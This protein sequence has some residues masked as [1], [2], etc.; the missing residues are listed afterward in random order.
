MSNQPHICHISTPLSWRGGEQ[1]AAYLIEELEALNVPQSMFCAAGGEFGKRMK[2]AGRTVETASKGFSTNPVFAWKLAKYARKQGAQVIHCHDSHALTFGYLA[3]V[4]FGNRIPLVASR[5]VDFPIGKSPFSLNKYN[6]AIVGRIL[7]VSDAIRDIVRPAL[8]RP[9][10]A[11]TVYSGV[12]LSRFHPGQH[13]GTLRKEFGIG[14]DVPLI[15]TV[16]ALA[17]HKDFPTWLDTVQQLIAN[18][19]NAHFVIIGDGPMKAAVESGIASRNL[20][21]HVTMAGFRTDVPDL[22]PELDMMLF[23]SKTEGLGTSL[24]DALASGTPIV[25]TRAG[26][27][28]EVIEAGKSGLLAPV[29]D[30]EALAAAACSLMENAAQRK[31][32]SANGIE[33]ATLFSQQETA[34]NTLA[35]YHDLLR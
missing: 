5:R 4:L 24:I 2:S 27:I 18:G 20:G 19:C 26:G 1:Q 32:F 15:G 33:R 30:V 8:K 13:S 29:G 17:D 16:A 10:V 9:E 34:Q 21:K 7:C 23:T 31:E 11:Q 28:P 25:A 14:D 3:T 22:L 12:D 35:V 6:H